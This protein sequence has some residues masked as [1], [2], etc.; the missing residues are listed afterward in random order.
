MWSGSVQG[1]VNLVKRIVFLAMVGELAWSNVLLVLSIARPDRRHWPPPDSPSRDHRMT[2][3]GQV[4]GPLTVPGLLALGIAD[5]NS[6][7]F[8]DRASTALG[9]ILFLLG[10]GF[11]LWGYLT[12]GVRA[13]QG[14]YEGL[15]ATGAYRHS[16]HPQYVGSIACF[17]G[18]AMVCKSRL[19]LVVWAL[20]SA[21]F[22]LAPF[23]EEP[24]LR[25][26]LGSAYDE[27]AANVPRFLGWPSSGK[28]VELRAPGL[29]RNP[30]SPARLE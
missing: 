29:E 7:P 18:Y 30:S 4:I 10:G 2:R 16:R 1:Q 15:V 23:A 8:S 24:W 25:D 3:I 13:S 12:L 28:A 6:S 21:W 19:T 14:Q 22:L 17:L 5:S 26:R 27:Y 11:A 9:A 20:W